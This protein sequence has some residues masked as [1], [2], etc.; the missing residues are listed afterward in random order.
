L[1]QKLGLSYAETLQYPSWNGQKLERVYP[2]GTIVTPTAAS[3]LATMKELAP[4][5]Y[6]EIKALSAVMRKLLGYEDL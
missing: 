2:W 5:E 6:A 1:C 4:E 3:N